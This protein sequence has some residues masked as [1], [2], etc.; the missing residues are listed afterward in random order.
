MAYLHR[1]NEIISALAVPSVLDCPQAKITLRTDYPFR[2]RFLY[3]LEARE[4]ISFRMRIPGF[5]KKLTVNG[6]P[7]T[8]VELHLEAGER[9]SLEVAFEADIRVEQR[10]YNLHTVRWGN[11]VFALPIGY[12][13][14]MLEYEKNGVERKFPYCDYE[15]LPKEPW[16]YGFADSG[17]TLEQREVGQVPFSESCPPVV[18]RT[19]LQQI[20]WGLEDRYEGVCAKVPASTEPVGE[21]EEKLLYPYGCAKLRMT[22]LPF[23][24]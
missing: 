17:F 21:P 23:V 12:D 2:N 16:N 11:L 24:S 6:A 1:G 8:K 15:Y 14:V 20:P 3:T 4:A 10:P 22:E 18:I 13:K 7:E 5:A 19:K 9:R